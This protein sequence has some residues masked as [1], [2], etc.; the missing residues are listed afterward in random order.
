[1]HAHF[2]TVLFGEPISLMKPA[3]ADSRSSAEWKFTANSER[4][5]AKTFSSAAWTETTSHIKGGIIE[6]FFIYLGFLDT[7]TTL[8][9]VNIIR[10]LKI[11]KHSRKS[12]IKSK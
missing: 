9:N 6:S 1:M 8:Y 10:E 2:G 5:S 3:Y 11:N 4:R 12:F 7:Q